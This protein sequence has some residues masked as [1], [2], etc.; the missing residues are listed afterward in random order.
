MT[1]GGKGDLVTLFYAISASGNVLPPMFIFLRVK[2]KDQI[3]RGSP[4]NFIGAATKSGWINEEIFVQFL[5]H[6][7]AQ[8]RCS[9]DN[10]IVL[11]TDNHESNTCLGTI[12]KD[13]RNGIYFKNTPIY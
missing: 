12:D 13:S 6:F 2:Y 5:G 8:T 10:K 11:I 1:P 9:K 7:V 4:N 3:I